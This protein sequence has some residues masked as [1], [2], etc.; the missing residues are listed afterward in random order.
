VLEVSFDKSL[1]ALAAENPKPSEKILQLYQE[2]V[3]RVA[4]HHIRLS[5]MTTNVIAHTSPCAVITVL[6]PMK[7][8]TDEYVEQLLWMHVLG[9]TP[10][11][12]LIR[13]LHLL[14]TNRYLVFDNIMTKTALLEALEDK[15]PDFLDLLQQAS[16][17]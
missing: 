17:V 10:D 11:D 12:D 1:R 9:N 7:D 8:V 13:V 4:R 2:H 16:E 15:D 14:A 3:P 6:I 5:S